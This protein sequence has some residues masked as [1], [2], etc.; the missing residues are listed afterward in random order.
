MFEGAFTMVGPDGK[1]SMHH[2]NTIHSY[3]L[4]KRDKDVEIV[5]PLSRPHVHRRANM[6]IFMDDG[7][8]ILTKRELHHSGLQSTELEDYYGCPV[9]PSKEH[10]EV[11]KKLRGP[12]WDLNAMESA[13]ERHRLRKRQSGSASCALP[14]RRLLP[15]GVAADC[16]YG[17]CFKW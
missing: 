3:G 17:N 2:I 11:V 12:D 16:T 10:Y 13:F 5:S 8:Q 1:S 15:M 9:A 7:Q 14:S 4:S 6:I